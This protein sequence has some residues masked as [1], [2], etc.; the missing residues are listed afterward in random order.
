M[1]INM[2]FLYFISIY[3]YIYI[4]IGLSIAIYIGFDN[5][6]QLL[7]GAH[8]MDNHFKNT[9]LENNLPVIL[10]V[11]GIWYNN[12][13]GAQTNAILPYDQYLHRFPAY[14]Q[15]VTNDSNNESISNLLISKTFV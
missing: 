13:F 3:I 7:T 9:P 12:F 14:F 1:L 5:F 11:L 6:H 4:A 8:D 10:G 2:F 15:Q